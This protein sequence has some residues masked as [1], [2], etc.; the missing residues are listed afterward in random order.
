MSNDYYDTLG[1]SENASPD[2]IKRTF[3]TLAK[4][5]HPDR[6]PDDTAAEARF[7]EISE[8]YDT[9]S[10]TKKKA[11]YDTMRKYGAFAGQPGGGGGFGGGGGG[12][13][14]F[15]Q[16]FH[17]GAGR[18]G[19]Q[20]FGGGSTG[21]IDGLDDILA[22]FFGG[23]GG[24]GGFGSPFGGQRR[25]RSRPARPTRGHDA[26]AWIKISFLES[27]TGT[28]RTIRGKTTGK[29]LAVKVPAG[30][31]DGDKIRLKGQGRPG[32]LG[33]ANG[34]LII[35]VT[36]M[37]D[38]QFERKGNDVHTRVNVPFTTAILGGKVTAKTLTKS[39]S[40]S[41]KPGTQPGTKLRLKG[42]GLAVG[43]ATGDQFVTVEV[44]IPTSISDRQRDL[45]EHWE[46]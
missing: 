27:V 22:Q 41:I 14:D 16:F 43:D 40:L 2:E 5:Y 45:L 29:K 21:G 28:K 11:E 12:G 1:V 20:T 8:A 18:G 30:I 10:D 44:E 7:K 42:M 35:T 31:D 9:L 25:Q 34:D 37:A 46:E 33:G 38:Q 23:G 39:V 15:S 17:Q 3:R 36:V 24:G 19:F 6:N 4:R 32:R 13:G 26:H